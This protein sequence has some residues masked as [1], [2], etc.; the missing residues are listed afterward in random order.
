MRSRG[1]N[2]PQ[3]LGNSTETTCWRNKGNLLAYQPVK[4]GFDLA[5]ES[6]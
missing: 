2:E 5:R 4:G 6:N 1:K 3:T